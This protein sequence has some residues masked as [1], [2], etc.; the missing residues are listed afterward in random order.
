MSEV[1]SLRRR[2]LRR[3]VFAVLTVYLVCSLSFLLVA[4]PRDPNTASVRQAAA[5]GATGNESERAAYIE[6]KVEAYRAANNLDDPLHERYV[7]WLVAITT[8]NWGDARSAPGSVT[9]AIGRAAPYTLAYLVPGFLLGAAMGV[10]SGAASALAGGRRV[11]RVV[12]TATYLLAGVPNFYLA[13]VLL[14][15]V[16]TAFGWD[17]TGWQSGP[18]P[19]QYWLRMALP[20]VV[21]A[22]GTLAAAHRHTRSNALARR[23]EDYVTLVTATGAGPVAKARHLLRPAAVPLLTL[24]YGDLLAALVVT[25][26]VVEYAFGIPGIGALSY[27][28]IRARD[29]PLVLG[30]T[31]VVVLVGVAGSWAQDVLHAVL[32]PRVREDG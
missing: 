30:T 10:A 9:D 19:A 28:A 15:L 8:L 22:T 7:R 29:V 20:A 21:T 12:S 17:A 18:W 26:Y 4:V 13:V 25:V 2:V 32:D 3:T 1:V 27:G 5:M 31:F 14:V 11:G 24:L 23:N 6:S 16:G